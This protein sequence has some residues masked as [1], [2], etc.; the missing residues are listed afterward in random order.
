MEGSGRGLNF[1][2]Y[3]HGICFEILG[4]DSLSAGRD[5][6]P[7]PSNYEAEVLTALPLRYV[8]YV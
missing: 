3:Y 8:T 6:N 2:R 4:L 1:E 7:G 5:L